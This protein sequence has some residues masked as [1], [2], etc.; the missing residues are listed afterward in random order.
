[1]LKIKMDRSKKRRALS[2]FLASLLIVLSVLYA[3]SLFSFTV[4][5]TAALEYLSSTVKING[6]ELE[7]FYTLQTDEATTHLYFFEEYEYWILVS[8]RYWHCPLPVTVEQEQES[9]ESVTVSAYGYLTSD[10]ALYPV[11]SPEVHEHDHHDYQLNIVFPSD[12]K[13][14]RLA[15]FT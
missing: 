14:P 10:Y 5:A 2:Y 4:A 13:Y 15:I 8:S 3:Q 11:K 1:M 9:G 12:R 6:E 7:L